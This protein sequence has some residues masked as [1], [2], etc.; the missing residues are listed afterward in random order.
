MRTEEGVPESE[1]GLSGLQGCAAL[2]HMKNASSKKERATWLDMAMGP[3]FRA[4][5]ALGSEASAH[6]SASSACMRAVLQWLLKSATAAAF[7]D[8]GPHVSSISMPGLW[9]S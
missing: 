6:A 8:L 2:D 7:E 4:A 3:L 9:S 5:S 1:A